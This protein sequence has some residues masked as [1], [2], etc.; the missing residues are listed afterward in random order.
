MDAEATKELLNDRA[1]EFARWL[2]PA[3]RKNGNEWLVG[4]VNGESGKSLGIRIEGDKVGLFKDFASGEGGSNLVE[5]FAQ[6]RKLPFTDALHACQEWLGDSARLIPRT[7]APK[8]K[9]HLARQCRNGA[10]V[11]ELTEQECQDARRMAETLFSDFEL[12]ER[13]AAARGWKPETLRQLGQE[14]HLGWHE[15]KLAFIYDTGAKLR[16]RSKGERIIRWA[17]LDRMVRR[18]ASH[19]SRG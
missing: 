1:E 2:F 18:K 7:N 12:C 13:I 14:V 19:H 11:Y 4:S 16:W 8:L 15:E 9:P 3:G 6:A 17:S 5:L 10:D